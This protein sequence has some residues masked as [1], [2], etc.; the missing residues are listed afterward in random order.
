MGIQ[1]VKSV[2]DH[3]TFN[4]HTGICTVDMHA[5]AT[6]NNQTCTTINVR[7]RTCTLNEYLPNYT[8]QSSQQTG[9]TLHGVVVQQTIGITDNVAV[10]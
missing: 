3:A 5:S 8:V 4:F 9:F 7:I 1:T 2:T 6:K 10:H